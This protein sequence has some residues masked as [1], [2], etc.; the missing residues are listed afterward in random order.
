MKNQ[1][2]SK[3]NKQ[4]KY[5]DV[6]KIN[7]LSVILVKFNSPVVAVTNKDRNIEGG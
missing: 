4:M 1:N 3:M 6:P 5:W 7:L 2:D